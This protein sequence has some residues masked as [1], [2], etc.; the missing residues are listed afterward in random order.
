MGRDRNITGRD[1]TETGQVEPR[2]NE[3]LDNLNLANRDK[4]EILSTEKSSIREKSRR[5]EIGSG[6]DETAF[7]VSS[8]REILVSKF[9]DPSLQTNS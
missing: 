6:R 8:R 3:K 2:L 5:D 1:E 9:L 4:I 7:L